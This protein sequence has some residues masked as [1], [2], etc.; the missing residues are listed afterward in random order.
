MNTIKFKESNRSESD[1]CEG[2]IIIQSLILSCG[3]CFTPEIW[4]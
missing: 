4:I 2:V 1:N 3:D